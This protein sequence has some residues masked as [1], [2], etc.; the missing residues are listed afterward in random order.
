MSKTGHTSY[1]LSENVRK[2]L[3]EIAELHDTTSTETLKRLINEAFRANFAEIAEMR[4]NRE[5]R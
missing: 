3:A 2:K 1:R 5:K 4:K